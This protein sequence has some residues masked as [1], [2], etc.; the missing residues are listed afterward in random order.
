M[1]WAWGYSRCV[2]ALE[3]IGCF[4]LDFI[5]FTGHLRGG[6]TAMLAGALDERA[7]IVNPNETCAGGCGCY[8]L[9][10][11]ALTEDGKEE[12][13]ET[14]QDPSEHFVFWFKAM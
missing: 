7:S 8:R 3:V 11:S 14:L 2:D 13:S 9:H 6:K 10:L 12:R 1:A 5:A 4:D